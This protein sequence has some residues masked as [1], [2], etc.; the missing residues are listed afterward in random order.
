MDLALV[1]EASIQFLDQW[2][3]L[4]STTNWEK[5]QIICQWRDTLAASGAPA[6]EFS[7]EAWS[8][9]VGHVTPQHV[10]RLRRAYE[11]FGQARV[12]YTGLYW[13]HF[14]AALDWDD[15]E[16]WL[17]GAAQNSW[18]ISEMRAQRWE[19]AGGGVELVSEEGAEASLPWDEDGEPDDAADDVPSGKTRTVRAP[20]GDYEFDD[21][22]ADGTSDESDSDSRYADDGVIASGQLAVAEATR[23][24][25]RPFAELPA[26]PADVN[27]AFE[28]Y[29]LAIL[30]HK[31][32]GWQEISRDDMLASLDALSQLVLAP[33]ES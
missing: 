18:S 6:G 24:A 25:V 33:A 8:R 15:A 13:S 14:Q 5:G 28:A 4:V 22:A 7:D 1:E 29:K 3:R 26:L 11:R 2:K 19:A 12:T 9:R 17:E 10:G 20:A 21:D 32:S 23:A 30:R 31:L 27:D 16:L